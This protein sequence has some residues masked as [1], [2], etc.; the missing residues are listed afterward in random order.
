M[1]L[2]RERK[3]WEWVGRDGNRD[4]GVVAAKGKCVVEVRW[5]GGSGMG[6]DVEWRME[7]VGMPQS[8]VHIGR[9]LD[10]LGRINS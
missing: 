4:G 9:Y 3:R 7:T 6:Y 2:T 1:A 10:S 5:C 8:L